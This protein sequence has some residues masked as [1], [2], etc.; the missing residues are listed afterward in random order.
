MAGGE[1]RSIKK[2]DFPSMVGVRWNYIG[3]RADQDVVT[4]LWPG[5]RFGAH[6]RVVGEV[7]R[8]A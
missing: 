8:L 7:K 4:P 1:Y 6:R 3:H 5:P 2:G